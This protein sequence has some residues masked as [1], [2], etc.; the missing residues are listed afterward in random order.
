MNNKSW[1]EKGTPDEAPSSNEIDKPEE[2]QDN[3]TTCLLEKAIGYAK[4]GWRVFPCKPEDKTPLVKWRDQAT[5]DQEAIRNWWKKYPGANIGVVTGAISGI[6]VVDVDGNEGMAIW[7]QLV[8]AHGFFTET[9]TAMTGGGGEHYYFAHP[10]GTFRNTA[11]KIGEHIDTRGDGG[12]V[13]APP[14]LHPNGNRYRW[15]NGSDQLTPAEMPSWLIDLLA[16]EEAEQPSEAPANRIGDGGKWLQEAL[17]KC[18]I[19]SRN[20]TGL[21]LACQLRDDGL[22]QEYV[23][24]IMRQYAAQVPQNRHRYTEQEAILTTQSVFSKISRGPAKGKRIVTG[25]GGNGSKPPDVT[26]TWEPLSEDEIEADDWL[27]YD[28]PLP[29]LPE[30]ARLP[31]ELTNDL[32]QTGRWLTDYIEFASKA[33][34]MS[35]AIFHEILGLSLLSTAIARRVHF[36]VS[37]KNIFSNIYAFI[38]ANST[39]YAKTTA[40]EV[41]KRTLDLAELSHLSLPVGITPQSLIGELTS[42]VPETFSNWDGEDQEDWRRERPYAAQRAWL[43]DETSTLLDS[44]DQKITADLLGLVL[45]LH[46]CPDKLQASSTIMRG[47]QTIRQAYL[48]ICGPTT[49][50]ALKQH[51]K[52]PKHWGNGLFARFLFVTPDRAPNLEF[53][54]PELEIPETIIEPLRK[55][56]LEYL[57]TPKETGKPAASIRV[58][59]DKGIW[60]RWEKYHAGLWTL[61]RNRMI[62]EKMYA[63]YGRF[64]NVALKIAMQL[65]TIDQKDPQED[66]IRISLKH[67]A[68]AQMITERYRA[69]LHRMVEIAEQPSEDDN[70]E[71]KIIKY[72]RGTA[73]GYSARELSQFLHMTKTSE[74]DE[75]ERTL[76][77]MI[78]DDL[79]FSRKRRGKRGPQALV[80][81][82][83]TRS[84]PATG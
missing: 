8:A 82:I 16:F 74:R 52:N 69:S 18:A 13:V 59:L 65:A 36:R 7:E 51:I 1:K 17:G 34:P 41:A 45:R 62:P 56:S 84:A 38:V 21:W 61:A 48:T 27:P 60:E 35:P 40:F 71:R 53:Y 11:A 20:A 81:L 32:E 2:L 63:N 6:V 75:L 25:S 12:Y 49:P 73:D 14:S 28:A 3:Y 80:F 78:G 37:N 4:R 5:V 42:R 47:R 33:S 24:E 30:E 55:L 26:E 57:P 67:M 83:K 39:L 72:L 15:M 19:G 29:L 66:G 44:F 70:I 46:D 43:M 31:D 50:A 77:R 54:P 64:H 10:G 22:S 23:E 58:Q 68:R 9:P 76:T 79:V